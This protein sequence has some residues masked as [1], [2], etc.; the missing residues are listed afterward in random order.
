MSAAELFLSAADR[1]TYD[2]GR[3]IGH[4]LLGMV[5]LGKNEAMKAKEQLEL[6]LQLYSPE[7]DAASTHMFGHDTQV[8]SRSLL[9]LALFCLGQVDEAL[10]VGVEALSAADAL[11]HPNSTAIALA[12]VGGWVFGLCGATEQLMHEARR[13]IAVSEQHRLGPFRAFGTAFL[14]WALCQHGD[15][16]QGITVM[17]QAIEAFDAIDFRLSITGHLANLADAKR[18]SGKFH[19]AEALCGRALE[20][21]S[22]SSQRWLE[23]EVRRIEALIASD[24]R[25]QQPDKAEDMLR[26]AA[27]CARDLGL[28]VFELRCLVSLR[29]F[30]GT[31][32]QDVGVESRMRELSHLRDLDRRVA[33]AMQRHQRRVGA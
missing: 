32:R 24:A 19:D 22:E 4:R 13:L 9:S 20:L 3:V 1:N 33:V 30:L 5:L 12:Y 27:I 11:R 25:P 28:P 23:P 29:D 26:S 15:L 21:V 31:T 8:H 6:S 17:E 10:R 18:T 16:Q 2:S 7:R 14:G